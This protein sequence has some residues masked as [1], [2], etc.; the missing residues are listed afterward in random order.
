MYSSQP[1]AGKDFGCGWYVMEV[2]VE[3]IKECDG[4]FGALWN[5]LMVEWYFYLLDENG[6]I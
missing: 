2:V 3:V 6:G 4:E 5:G 1:D